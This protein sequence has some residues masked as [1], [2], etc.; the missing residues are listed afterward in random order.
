MNNQ[1]ARIEYRK[2][3]QREKECRQAYHQGDGRAL[4]PHTI[5]LSVN[6]N[7]YMKCRMCD[8][9]MSNAAREDLGDEEAAISSR[10][11]S[12]VYQRKSGYV[13][14]PLERLKEIVDEVSSFH[15]IIKANLVEP[16]LYGG[17]FELARYTKEKG[18]KFYT[19]TNGWRLQALATRIVE[20]Q[21]I[22]LI[23]VSLD[24]PEEI[25]D[26]IRGIKGSF[27]RTTQGILELIQRKNRHGVLNP[28]VGLC[29]TI[30]ALNFRHLYPFM[31]VLE[32]LNILPHV[33]INFNHLYYTTP[34]EVA[35]TR[36]ESDM[37]AELR[38][39]S[40]DP[41]LYE[42]VDP[43]LLAEEI[44][45]VKAR[46]DTSSHH[47]YFSPALEQSDLKTYYNPARRMSSRAPCYLPWYAAQV[48][49][50]G[51]V[52]VFGHCILPPFGNI[53]TESFA[54]VWNSE[55]ACRIRNSLHEAGSYTACNKCIGTLYP[56]RGRD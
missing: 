12:R 44:R 8:I 52:G 53:M 4:P 13:E 51:N 3:R 6:N 20:E 24:G 54:G 16:L 56:L 55:A 26:R 37:F 42:S 7:C 10:H 15:P 33:Y 31:E 27:Q 36:E 11:F 48:A 34:P 43:S 5:C 17:L 46:F 49:I 38:A 32:E 47:Y 18:L 30:N 25:H 29:F 41:G 21:S 23:R 39:C 14:F 50:D 2:T 1:L 19:L 28:I 9:G 40:A 45:R 35:Q 22:D